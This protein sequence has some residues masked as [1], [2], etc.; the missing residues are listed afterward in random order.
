[1]DMVY[2]RQMGAHRGK[3]LT[4]AAPSSAGKYEPTQENITRLVS[5]SR[6]IP[7]DLSLYKEALTHGSLCE[8]RDYQRLEFL[9][10]RVLGMVIASLLYDSY[11]DASEGQMSAWLNRLV[12]R[13]NC[14]RIARNMELAPYIRLGKQA[15]DDGGR[16]SVNI[17]G[18][19][20]EAI[21]GALYIDGGMEKACYFI[22]HHWMEQLSSI[23]QQPKHPKSALQESAAANNRKNPEYEIVER[24]GPHHDLRFTISVRIKNVGEASASGSSKRE[25]EKRAAQKFLDNFAQ[26]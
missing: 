23:G 10:D 7:V 14:A 22:E 6:H 17:L 1:M 9:G 13:E 12:S 3:I 15:R 16:D 20:V 8:D 2:R 11:P 19:V 25:A 21:I 4:S 5:H 26:D 24:S 18:D